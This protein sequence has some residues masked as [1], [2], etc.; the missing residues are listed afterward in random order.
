MTRPGHDL[1]VPESKN[2][3]AY[4]TTTVTLFVDRG[5][6]KSDIMRVNRIIAF[7]S[8]GPPHNPSYTGDHI[9]R[10]RGGQIMGC[11]SFRGSEHAGLLLDMYG[12]T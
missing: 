6:G 1:R 11:G 3:D 12:H 8:L 4:Q 9:N 2:L 5:L 10:R 7:T